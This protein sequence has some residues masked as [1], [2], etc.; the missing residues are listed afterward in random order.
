ME[1]LEHLVIK[2]FIEA[3]FVDMG[4]ETSIIIEK[5]TQRRL[6]NIGKALGFGN[7]KPNSLIG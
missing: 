4:G 1:L 7:S 5:S 2:G 3:S 6:S